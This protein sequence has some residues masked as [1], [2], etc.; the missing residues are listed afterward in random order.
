MR[1]LIL[2]SF[3]GSINEEFLYTHLVALDAPRTL[4]T[5]KKGKWLSSKSIPFGIMIYKTAY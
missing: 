2:T 5:I 3:A 1:N 4:E